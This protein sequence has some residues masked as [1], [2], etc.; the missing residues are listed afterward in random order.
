MQT[1]SSKI[2]DLLKSVSRSGMS[3]LIY[4]L[5]N[6]DFFTAP[7]SANHHL[8]RV[9]GLE[10]HSWNVYKLLKE[11]NK[12]YNLGLK[13]SSIIICGLLHD[14]CK[15]NYY[16]FDDD[17]MCYKIKDSFPIGHGEKSVIILSRFIK[18][19]E[20]ECCMIRWHMAGFD[21]SDYSQRTYHEAIKKYPS[22]LALHTA[23]YESTVFLE[24]E[25]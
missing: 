10:R 9:G 11:K 17:E 13:D 3:E 25:L 15:V 2:L 23:D 12:R 18:L 14:I 21:L 22:C 7:C 20:Q 6:S 19:T 8:N 4:W 5:Q 24:C 16:H 1:I